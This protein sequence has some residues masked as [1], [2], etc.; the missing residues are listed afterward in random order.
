VPII[1]LSALF[2]NTGRAVEFR[3]LVDWRKALIVLVAAVPTCALGAWGYTLLTGTG[4]LIVIGGMLLLSVP[5]R[6]LMRRRG[7]S[8]SDRSLGVVAFAWGPLA[9]GT[10][11]AG[12]ILLSLLM[13]AGL[14]GAGVVA[15]DAIISIAIGLTK[16]VVFGVAGAVDAKVIAVAV[17]IGAVTFPGAFLAKALVARLPLHLHTA[18]LDVVVIVGGAVMLINAFVR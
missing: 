11:G 8:L 2:T 16:L 1:S 6:R 15:T 17:L 12:I 5:L 18:L 3:H 7:L 9:G 14:Q 10:V 4:A 13:S